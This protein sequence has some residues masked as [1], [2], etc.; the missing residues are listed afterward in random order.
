MVDQ[1]RWQRLLHNMHDGEK[2]DW[3]CIFFNDRPGSN[4]HGHDSRKY[5]T[6]PE[7]IKKY[8]NNVAI[9]RQSMMLCF[10]NFAFVDILLYI[11]AQ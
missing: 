3:Q 2:A 1:Y 9:W 7:E 4:D 5:I 11:A 8:L 6:Q 10:F